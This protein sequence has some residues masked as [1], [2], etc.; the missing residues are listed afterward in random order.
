MAETEDVARWLADDLS[1]AERIA[2]SQ[3]VAANP[4]LA[5][6]LVDHA[7]CELLL[8]AL[9]PR[10]WPGRVP[11]R[12]PFAWRR[13]AAVAVV[14]AALLFAGGAWWWQRGSH[15]A[16]LEGDTWRWR[17]GTYAVVEQGSPAAVVQAVVPLWPW[18]PRQLRQSSGIVRWDVAP[19]ARGMLVDLHHGTLEV[20][21]TVF[22]T[23][24]HEQRA[25][26]V[27]TQGAVLL[28]T[29][30]APQA[31]RA[32]WWADMSAE[33]LRVAPGAPA[34]DGPSSLWQPHPDELVHG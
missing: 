33:G 28:R 21:G 23:A 11:L 15:V 32:G 12:G 5:Q 17:D 22:A 10:Q 20:V 1:E 26:V 13:L 7:R 18:S 3:R 2:F 14:A 6:R 29:R 9:W 8:Q 4:E 24:V 19:Q 25:R 16:T 30:G 34:V 27:L 31:L